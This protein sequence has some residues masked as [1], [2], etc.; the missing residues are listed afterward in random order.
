MLLYSHAGIADRNGCIGCFALVAILY[1]FAQIMKN[2]KSLQIM[3]RALR[4]SSLRALAADWPCDSCKSLF[5]F[6]PGLG[7]R[8]REMS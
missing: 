7:G 3:D 5:C 1:H 6:A 2:K 8:Q 4:F